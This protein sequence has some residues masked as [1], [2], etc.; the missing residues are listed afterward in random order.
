MSGTFGI[1]PSSPVLGYRRQS[2]TFGTLPRQIL[3]IKSSRRVQEVI[4]IM[5]QL[6]S[7]VP[8]DDRFNGHYFCLSHKHSAALELLAVLLY[9]IRHLIDVNGNKMVRNDMFQLLEPE[10]RDACEE[11]ALIW[12]TLEGEHMKSGRKELKD[13][14]TLLR[15]ISYTD[16]RSVATN[17]K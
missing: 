1:P 15:M 16:I 6:T 2:A 14:R 3:F 10:Q 11:F 17:N 9:F 13:P 4:R 12:N 8:S 7:Y 5:N